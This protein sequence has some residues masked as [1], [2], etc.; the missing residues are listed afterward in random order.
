MIVKSAQADGSNHSPQPSSSPRAMPTKANGDDMYQLAGKGRPGKQRHG[1]RKSSLKSSSK[2]QDGNL[3]D[4]G[5]DNMSANKSL[6]S[7]WGARSTASARRQKDGGSTKSSLSLARPH[8]NGFS[9]S[10]SNLLADESQ[11]MS[12]RA[13]VAGSKTFRQYLLGLTTD[14]IFCSLLRTGLGKVRMRPCR[15]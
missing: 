15:S 13:L 5:S 9:A 8:G 4:D 6:N 3:S 10:E 14:G 11:T 12:V 7:K 1:S 2:D